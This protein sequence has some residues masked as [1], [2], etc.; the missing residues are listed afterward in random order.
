[1]LFAPFCKSQK[2]IHLR[3]LKCI[4]TMRVNPELGGKAVSQQSR[5]LESRTGV[6][7]SL[8]WWGRVYWV[9]SPGYKWAQ[10]LHMHMAMPIKITNA[11]TLWLSHST[12]RNVLIYIQ[13]IF[14]HT[15]KLM[16]KV[17]HCHVISVLGS[18]KQPICP[19]L[20]VWLNKWWYQ[21]YNEVL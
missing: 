6:T 16:P 10:P 1:M 12:S 2:Q 19:S 7:P 15:K 5:R 21:P 20:G 8:C 17:I 13:V 11:F 18:Y 14:T 3:M 4:F 9:P